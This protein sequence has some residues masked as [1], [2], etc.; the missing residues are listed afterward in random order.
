MKQYG[1]STLFFESCLLVRFKHGSQESSKYLD[2]SNTET[3]PDLNTEVSSADVERMCY[4]FAA[5]QA[6]W[7]DHVGTEMQDST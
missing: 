7:R 4:F 5:A 6:K 2:A 1:S 3:D